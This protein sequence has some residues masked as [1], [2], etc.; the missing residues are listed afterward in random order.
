MSTLSHILRSVASP[1]K[2]IEASLEEI[3]V[4]PLEKQRVLRGRHGGCVGGIQPPFRQSKAGCPHGREARSTS[5]RSMRRFH[6]QKHWRALR[7]Q[8]ICEN[9]DVQYFPV[10]RAICKLAIRRGE[11]AWQLVGH[12]RNRTFLTWQ[13]MS[14]QTKVR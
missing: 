11:K 10:H 12:C 9:R 2:R 13:P 5:C 4:H 7:G 1:K 14:F 6:V 3:L 8:R